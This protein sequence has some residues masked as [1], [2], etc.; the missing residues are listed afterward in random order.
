M[1]TKWTLSFGGPVVLWV[2]GL[3][4]YNYSR[5]GDPLDF[6]YSHVITGRYAQFL[7]LTLGEH[8]FRWKHVPYQLHYYLLSL[9]K[10]V[11]KFPYLRY[12]FAEFW[13]NDVYLTRELVCSVFA[14]M[15]V[16][17]LS[18]PFPLLVRDAG[19]RNRLSL[20]LVF[21][22]VSSL[23]IV[24]VLSAFYGSAARYYFEF[25]PLLFVLSFCTLAAFWDRITTNSRRKTAAKVALSLLFMGNVFMG[26]LLGLTG[27]MQY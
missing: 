5:F 3:L 23:A 4:A 6:G 9:P 27:A 19:T 13:V 20:I 15:P 17:L 26:L 25:T 2:C 10:I 11:S 22:G 24:A 7:Y 12:P 14:A 21:F 18:L 1:T 8:L 16:L